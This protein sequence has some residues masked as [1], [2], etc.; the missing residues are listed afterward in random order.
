M[1]RHIVLITAASYSINQG[2]QFSVSI[3][4]QLGSLGDGSPPAGPQARAPG[5]GLGEKPPKA[6]HFLLKR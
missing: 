2:R 6:E 1:Y 3:G 5:G 4:G